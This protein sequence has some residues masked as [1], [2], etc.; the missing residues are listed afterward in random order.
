MFL[1]WTYIE[2]I[3]WQINLPETW[4]LQVTWHYGWLVSKVLILQ[5]LSFLIFHYCNQKGNS[6]ANSIASKKNNKLD[7]KSST[8][9]NKDIKGFSWLVPIFCKPAQPYWLHVFLIVVNKFVIYLLKNCTFQ[10]IGSRACN[11]TKF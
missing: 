11:M 9:Q 1:R 2:I 8:N 10:V 4:A 5:W 6:S 7:S 3:F